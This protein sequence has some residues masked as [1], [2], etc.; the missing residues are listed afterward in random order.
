MF[1]LKTPENTLTK[2]YI[3]KQYFYFAEAYETV[4]EKLFNSNCN[5]LVGL[6]WLHRYSSWSRHSQ[7]SIEVN[8]PPLLLEVYGIKLF[9]NDLQQGIVL[10]MVNPEFP[11]VLSVSYNTCCM[12]KS[13]IQHQV[14]VLT[15]TA[16]KLRHDWLKNSI[17][18][19]SICLENI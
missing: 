8:V 10:V 9:V 5:L 7:Y 4:K 12:W 18:I 3:I 11:V 19:L 1:C 14:E 15:N 2:I 16:S 17:Q 6:L 13:I